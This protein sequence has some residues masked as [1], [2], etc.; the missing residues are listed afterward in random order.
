MPSATRSPRGSTR[1]QNIPTENCPLVVATARIGISGW[2]Y[3]PW[4]G[5]FYPKGVRQADELDYA[6]A[7]L[8]SIEI[9]GSFYSLQRPTSWER[10]RDATPEGFVFAVK[11]PRYVTHLLRL[12]NARAALANFF[13]SGLLTLGPK[14]G[15]LLWQLPPRF[16][17]DADAFASFCAGL[18][19]TTAAALEIAREHEERMTGRVALRIDAERPL[20]HAVEVRD[21]SWDDPRMLDILRRHG[22]AC[23]LADTAGRYPVLEHDTAAFR[24]VRLH[25][26]EELYTSGYDPPALDRWAGRMRPWLAAGQEVFGYFDNDVKVRAPFDAM[27]L[28]ARLAVP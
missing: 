24:Y 8:N 11:G 9:N 21:P 13:A 26:D 28:A 14:L 15:P 1:P 4:R 2:T 19:T 17:F 18:P 20:R 6:S 25:G 16:A 12:R 10:W 5:V 22:I 23:V 3:A 7:R 27:A